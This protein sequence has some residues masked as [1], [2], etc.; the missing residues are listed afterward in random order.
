MLRNNQLSIERLEQRDL[1]AGD[2]TVY[3]YGGDLL[4]RGDHHDNII[5]VYRL[6]SGKTRV[7][8]V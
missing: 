1:M 5:E 4:I 3:S 8:G 7:A 2:V 6:S